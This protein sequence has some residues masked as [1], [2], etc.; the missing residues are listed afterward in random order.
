MKNIKSTNNTN[1]AITSNKALTAWAVE[2]DGEISLYDVVGTR[3]LAR[4]MRND[5]AHSLDGYPAKVSVRKVL[6]MPIKGR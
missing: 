4:S 1:N 5:I 2:I 6:I 3:S